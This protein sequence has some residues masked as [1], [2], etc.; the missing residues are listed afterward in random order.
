MQRWSKKRRAAA[1]GLALTLPLALSSSTEAQ[2]PAP[3]VPPAAPPARSVTLD[4]VVA[5]ALR[6]NSSVLLSQ[7]RLRKAQEQI[8]Q[9]DAQA[10]P[11]IRVDVTDTLSSTRTFATSG[12]SVQNP[13]L[14]GGGQIPVIVDQGGGNSS[15]FV[16]GGGGGTTTSNGQSGVGIGGGT[17]VGTGTGTGG[18]GTTTGAGTGGTNTGG[19]GT[20][21][22]GTGTGTTGTGG[23]GGNGGQG[24]GG[25]T[26]TGSSSTGAANALIALAE[27]PSVVQ[28]YTAQS[29]ISSYTLRQPLRAR[30]PL[31]GLGSTTG[32]GGA[33]GTTTGATRGNYNNYGGRL[34]VTQY[35]DIFNLVGTARDVENIT[36]DFYVLDLERVANET[37]LS[38]KNTFFN[39][40]RAQDQVAVQQEQVNFATENLRIAQAR[41]NAG[42]TARFD[43][44]TAQTNLANAQQL[45]SQSQNQLAL[46]QANLNNLLGLSQDQP[47]APQTPPLPALN[48]T[49]DPGQ[50]VRT[51]YA[52]RPELQQADKNI[53]IAKKLVR[54]AGSSLKPTLG[55]VAGANY[56]G[57][58]A[59]TSDGKHETFSL[60]AVLGIPLYDG[61]TTRSRV[62][63]AQVDLETQNITKSQLVQNVE[64]EVRQALINIAN[65]QT[66]TSASAQAV[67]QAEEAVRLAQVRYQNGISTF[68]EVTNAQAN[69]AQARTNLSGAQFDYQT[70]L[71]Q[72]TRAEGGR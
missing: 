4:E 43:V 64:L 27:L 53:V 34:S 2:T 33:V 72:L 36:R 29:R 25:A 14:P 24:T 41:F 26:G 50:T 22:G 35:L 38:A 23:A 67:S 61:G 32:T 10:R 47:L 21:T 60:S 63:S 19:F 30:Q 58:S 69:L 57:P 8:A 48:Q 5:T 45:L 71:A 68:L 6:N 18:T 20:G 52:R 46:T 12:G 17:G 39:V 66:R 54:L 37:A 51:A 59:S 40:L 42:A 3:L 16:G 70:A 65:A 7:E 44:L 11:Q 28:D 9:I 31:D 55:L 13:S 56:A 15:G 1:L 62:R 49:F